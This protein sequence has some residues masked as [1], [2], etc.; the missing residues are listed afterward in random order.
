MSAFIVLVDNDNVVEL[1]LINPISGASLNGATVAIT[2]VDSSGVEVSGE[3]WPLSI[4]FVA[5]S[6]GI[7]RATLDKLIEFIAGQRYK[8]TIT[9]AESGLDATWVLDYLAE[10][11]DS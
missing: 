3:T 8:A 2:I 10:T 5:N 4:P 7:Y 1:E 9:A 11:R 6:D